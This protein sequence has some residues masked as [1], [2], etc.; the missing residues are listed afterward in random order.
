M[1]GRI[2]VTGNPIVDAAHQN[3]AIARRRHA[4][5]HE[6]LRIEPGRYVIATSHREENVD[7]PDVLA[8]IVRGLDR[9]AADLDMPVVFAPTRARASGSASSA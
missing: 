3:L 4:T 2:V 9:V 7:H 5:V 6:Q 1:R 8:D